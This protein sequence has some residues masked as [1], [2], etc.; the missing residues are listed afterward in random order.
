MFLIMVLSLLLTGVF[1]EDGLVDMV[2]GVGG[3]MMVEWCLEI[4]KDSCIGIYGF[5]VLIMVLLGKY[6]LFIELVDF[7]LLVF[8]WL[9]V[10]ILSCVVVVF[11]ICNMFYVFDI[12]S[13]KSKLLV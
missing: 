4:M 12:D 8:V 6:L 13:S 7:I 10:Y 11:L 9:L 2:D 1:Y 3:G 5:S